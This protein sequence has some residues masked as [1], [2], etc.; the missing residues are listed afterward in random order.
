MVDPVGRQAGR[1]MAI[2]SGNNTICSI[3]MDS[4]RH[5][6]AG[7]NGYDGVCCNNKYRVQCES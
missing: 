6:S 5:S 2:Y 7:R 4:Y 1:V 3:I